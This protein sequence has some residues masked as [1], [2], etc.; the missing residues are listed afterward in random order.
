[1]VRPARVQQAEISCFADR[2]RTEIVFQH[3]IFLAPL[4]LRLRSGDNWGHIA[5]NLSYM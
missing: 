3:S 4:E 1:M 5:W 2:T